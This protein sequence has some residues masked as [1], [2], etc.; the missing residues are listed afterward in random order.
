ML[1]KW[2]D[3]TRLETRT[4]EFSVIAS[5]IVC[6]TNMRNESKDEQLGSSRW[7]KW[8]FAEMLQKEMDL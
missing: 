7:D 2:F 4:K 3:T 6:Q 5:I 8:E 1:T